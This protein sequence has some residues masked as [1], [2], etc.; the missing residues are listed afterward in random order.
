MPSMSM[1][2]REAKWRSFSTSW[3]GHEAPVQRMMAPSSS[4]DGLG[5]AHRAVL[6]E[7]VGLGARAGAW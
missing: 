2:V 5:A 4:S 3:A 7:H 1:A 6:G